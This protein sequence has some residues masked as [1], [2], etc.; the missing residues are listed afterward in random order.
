MAWCLRYAVD[1]VWRRSPSDACLMK[2]AVT[3]GNH[4]LT[5]GGSGVARCSS[6]RST[7][8]TVDVIGHLSRE[9]ATVLLSFF[10]TLRARGIITGC[11]SPVYLVDSFGRTQYIPGSIVASREAS[12]LHLCHC[13]C[14][15]LR[16]MDGLYSA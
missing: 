1:L 12:I 13:D 6:S 14:R 4:V 5:V 9:E 3:H 11:Q 15:H 10:D 8:E 7:D 16:P 2:A